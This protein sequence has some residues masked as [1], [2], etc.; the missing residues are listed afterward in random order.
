MG[1]K[2]TAAT[3]THTGPFQ[4]L[5]EKAIAFQFA[6]EFC[7]HSRVS[8]TVVGLQ[9][10]S[11]FTIGYKYLGALGRRQGPVVTIFFVTARWALSMDDHRALNRLATDIK[12][13][14]G[15][16]WPMFAILEGHADVRGDSDD[17]RDLSRRRV[18]KVAQAL[19]KKV[20]NKALFKVRLTEA[21]G[22]SKATPG[23]S[24]WPHDRRVEIFVSGDPITVEDIGD[25]KKAAKK[26]ERVFQI[27]ASE[28][29][30]WLRRGLF[31][32]VRQAEID[33]ARPVNVRSWDL[34]K[35]E[36]L[37]RTLLRRPD[38]GY[39]GFFENE[40]RQ[41]PKHKRESV[42][43]KWHGIIFR[44]LYGRAVIRYAESGWHLP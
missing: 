25:A 19:V 23:R 15:K 30:E 43:V 13:F 20:G 37:L 2:L 33:E 4:R 24:H 38:I 42:L 1:Q 29:K 9:E 7:N 14:T 36:D 32:L 18:D 22:E 44:R 28:A 31:Y 16:R 5:D 10:T 3:P 6:V 11:E 27:Y 40:L 34:D 41:A 35:L 21:F 17:N 8:S 39:I 12:K 26:R